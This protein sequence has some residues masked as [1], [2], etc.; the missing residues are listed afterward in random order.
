MEHVESY[1]RAQGCDVVKVEVFA[2]N[3]PA[4][5]LYE[6]SGYVWRDIDTIKK[7]S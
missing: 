5:S 4:R 2:P 1:F 7:L 6:K 3:A